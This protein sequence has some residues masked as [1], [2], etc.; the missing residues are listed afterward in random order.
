MTGKNIKKQLINRSYPHSNTP[1]D[2]MLK[3]LRIFSRKGSIERW[4]TRAVKMLKKC[5]NQFRK[6]RVIFYLPGIIL[7]KM[8]NIIIN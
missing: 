4:I 6:W 1:D 2:K 5:R 8:T 7:N 3:I